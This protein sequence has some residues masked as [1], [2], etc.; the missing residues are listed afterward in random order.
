[1]SETDEYLATCDSGPL[2]GLEITLRAPR[3]MLAVDVPNENAWVYFRTD[4]GT[5]LTVSLDDDESVIQP[6]GTHSGQRHLDRERAVLT[7]LDGQYDVVAL[8]QEPQQQEE[9]TG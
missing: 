6:Y 2:N 7:A 8:P 3:G 9:V 4:G 5:T 1:M